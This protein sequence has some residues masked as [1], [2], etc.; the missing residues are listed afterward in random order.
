M[1]GE[2][3]YI[4]SNAGYAN[5]SNT[6]KFR[7]FVSLVGVDRES[8]SDTF[9]ISGSLPEESYPSY[10]TGLSANPDLV[11][12]VT[13][14]EFGGGGGELAH[15]IGAAARGKQWGMKFDYPSY[16]GGRF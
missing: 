1:S 9:T 2:F 11:I 14:H 3:D 10:S 13:S 12:I 6:D 8:H 16:L 5:P 7:N 15:S 4:V